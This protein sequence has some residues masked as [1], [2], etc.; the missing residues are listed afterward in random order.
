VNRLA[1]AV[2]VAGAV[3]G[4]AACGGAADGERRGD[5]AY[6]R[7]QYAQALKEYRSLTDG[8]AHPRIWA[9]AGAAALRTGQL[10]EAADAYLHLA[11]EDPSRV[12]EAA[13]GLE[14]VAREAERA[15]RA[16]A[17]Q[18]AVVGLQS[19]APDRVPGR[20]ALL[21][22]QQE[23]AEPSELVGLL[24]R[25][26]AAAPDQATVDS[27]LSLHARLLQ[28][29]SGCGQAMFQYRAVLRR[30]QD[31]TLRAQARRGAADCALA[32]GRRSASGGREEDAALWF[33]E[34]ARM[35]SSSSVG[36]RAL[37]AYGETRLQQGDTLAAALAYQAI[38]SDSTVSDSIGVTARVRLA[39]LGLTPA[40]DPGRGVDSP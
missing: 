7:A 19:V 36:R 1:L 24:P 33:A 39:R 29:T 22:A 8:K 23:G 27:L 32:L 2:V 13:E 14:A 4:S 37:L 9:K 40:T 31:S 11:G 26:I 21:L 16:D 35:D 6:G 10:Q 34:A 20:Y 18:Q 28:Q 3:C 38:A 12:Q 5:E 30:T 15:D 17:L 25:A